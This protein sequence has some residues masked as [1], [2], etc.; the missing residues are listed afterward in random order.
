MICNVY[1]IKQQGNIGEIGCCG[2]HTCFDVHGRM[3]G[4]EWILLEFVVAGFGNIQRLAPCANRLAH[5]RQQRT[6]LW[7]YIEFLIILFIRKA[8]GASE[9][10]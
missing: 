8:H 1:K 10:R 9:Y 3:M 6:R 2:K 5:W 7:K 4:E